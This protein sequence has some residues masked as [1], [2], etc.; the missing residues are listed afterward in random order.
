MLLQELSK[1]P[2][3]GRKWHTSLFRKK[4][5]IK[6]S[7]PGIDT[8]PQHSG[9]QTSKS[10]HSRWVC[11]FQGDTFSVFGILNLNNDVLS[12]SIIVSKAQKG[13]FFFKTK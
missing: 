12:H 2:I 7:F 1:T 5:L 6:I 3:S 4:S 13:D 8:Q 9:F 11:H 10:S